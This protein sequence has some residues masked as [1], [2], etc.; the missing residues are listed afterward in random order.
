MVRSYSSMPITTATGVPS[1]LDRERLA[2]FGLFNKLG[3]PVSCF[4]LAAANVVVGPHH[5]AT[6]AE[7]G[8]FGE[9]VVDMCKPCRIIS[10]PVRILFDPS[11]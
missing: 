5:S 3:E 9:W 2:T 6:P 8:P 11:Q 4:P 1:R 10:C 7:A